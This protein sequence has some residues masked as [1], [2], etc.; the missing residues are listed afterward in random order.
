[1]KSEPGCA[2]VK[3]SI[4]FPSARHANIFCGPSS[5]G[6][7]IVFVTSVDNQSMQCSIVRAALEQHF[8]LQPNAEQPA[9]V[10]GIRQ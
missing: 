1:M 9:D 6:K 7:I 4:D 10:K 3:P 5:A 2:L 8:W